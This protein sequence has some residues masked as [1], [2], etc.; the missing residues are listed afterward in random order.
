[1][2]IT[3]VGVHA[4]WPFLSVG[5]VAGVASAVGSPATRALT[6]EI[7]LAELLAGAIALRSVASQIGIVAGP[8]L[9]GIIFAVDPVSVYA[10]ALALL[11]VAVAAIVAL[12]Y[13]AAPG[14]GQPPPDLSSLVASVHFILR[15]RMLLGAISLDLFAVLLGDSIALAPVFARSILDVGPIGLG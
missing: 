5:A 3:I 9:G 2:A 4:L 6:P 13:R 7:V 1:L 15:T 10:V 8:A 14:A 11:L 12:P